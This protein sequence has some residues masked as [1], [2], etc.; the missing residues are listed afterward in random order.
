MNGLLNRPLLLAL[1][2][3][4]LLAAAQQQL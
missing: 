2:L 4:A 1:G 3:P